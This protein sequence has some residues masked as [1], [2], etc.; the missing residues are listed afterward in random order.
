M[1]HL[2]SKTWVNDYPWLKLAIKTVLKFCKDPVEWTIVGDQ[3][4]KQDIEIVVLQAVQESK[5]ALRYKIH[6]VEEFWPEC[7]YISNK[8]LAQQWIKMNAHMVMGDGVFWN[9]DCDVI[10][11]K[12]FSIETFTG[13]SGRPIYWFSQFNS[14]M[15]GPDRPA[16]EARMSMMKEVLGLPEVS[17]EWMRCM[18]I[19]LHGSILR[20]GS[21]RLEWK[22]SFEM[23]KVGDPRFSEFN[24]IGQFAHLYFPD[25]Y[26]W[27]NAETS[28]PTWSSGY[29]EGGKGSG[30]IQEHACVMQG[31]SWNGVPPHIQEFVDSL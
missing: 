24:V 30:F 28:G 8:Y 15:T 12:P 26:E 19:A 18:P 6:E 27:R 21:S 29:V 9:W 25:A 22:K 10:A 14:L 16:H 31:W 13:K 11:C 4:S 23:M 20:N 7:G 3:G 17:I 2:F 5:G 1:I